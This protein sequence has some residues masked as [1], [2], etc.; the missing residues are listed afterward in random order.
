MPLGVMPGKAAKGAGESEDLPEL[1][2]LLS[3]TEVYPRSLDKKGTSR[4]DVK[5]GPGIFL[6]RTLNFTQIRRR[7]MEK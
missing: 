4:I 5:V 1:M 7:R 6:L 2:A 3:R